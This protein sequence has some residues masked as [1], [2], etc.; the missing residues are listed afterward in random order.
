MSWMDS[1]TEEERQ[2]WLEAG[3]IADQIWDEWKQNGRPRTLQQTLLDY[4][5]DHRIC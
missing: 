1:M 2:A 3:T 5:T 4:E